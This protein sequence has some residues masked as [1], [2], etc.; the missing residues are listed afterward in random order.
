MRKCSTC[1]QQKPESEFYKKGKSGRLNSLCK[2]CF[3]DYCRRDGW[4]EKNLLLNIWV[5]N[6]HVAGITD[7]MPLCNSTMLD[8]KV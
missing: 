5:E 2:E 4:I 3:N 1:Q 8:N 6:A 7:T